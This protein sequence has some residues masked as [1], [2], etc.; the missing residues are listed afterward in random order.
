MGPKK[1]SLVATKVCIITDAWTVLTASHATHTT[2]MILLGKGVRGIK[3]KTQD[4][5]FVLTRKNKNFANLV[6]RI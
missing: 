2:S 5:F 4:T 3:K 1:G 6:S